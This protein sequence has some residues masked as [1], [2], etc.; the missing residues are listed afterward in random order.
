MPILRTLRHLALGLTLIAAAAAL[1]LFSDRERRSEAGPRKVVRVALVQHASTPALDEGV[2]GLIQGLAEQGFRDGEAITLSTYNAQGDLA[3]GNAIARQ[4]TTG[5]FDLVL[6]TSTPSM[7]AVANANRDGR[8][9]HVFT[10]VADPFGAGVG[11]DRDH[12][13]K[14]PPHMVG[15]GS[16]LPVADGF[17]L[18]KQALPSLSRVGVAWNPAE[19]NSEAFTLRAREACRQ[20]G[21][22]LLEA[23]VD[24]SAAV[25]EAVQSLVAR[26]AQALWVGGDNTMMS[27]IGSAIATA[28]TSRIPVFTI[29]PGAPDRGTLF[30]IGLDFHELGRIGGLLAG[31]VLR[32]EDPATIPIRDVQD[33]VP[34]RMVV[35]TVAL[36][37]LRDPWQIPDAAMA[38]ATVVVD[39]T[40]T[41]ERAARPG[42][43][44]RKWRVD[45]I[46]YN[47]VQDVE[48]AEEGVKAGFRESGLVE[49]RDYT[50]TVRNAQ[51]D[52]A[53]VSTLVDAALSERADMLVTFSTPTL[54]AA[55]QRARHVPI[56][57]TYVSSPHA[58]GAGR[59]DTDHL[60]N[61]TG[62]YMAPAYGDMIALIRRVMPSVKSLGTLFVPAEV[63]SV[64]NR[65]LLQ[66]ACRKAGLTLIDVPANTS[67]DVPDASLALAARRPDAICQIPGNLTA[68]AFPTVQQAASRARLPIFAFQTSQ[69]H[70]GAVVTVARDYADAGRQSA[71]L[72]V[73]VMRGERPADMPF[74]AVGKTRLVVNPSAARR[75]GITI[76]PDLVAKADEVVGPR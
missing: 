59:S 56:V 11:L 8:V 39:A 50:I 40:G 73:R 22:T 66:A 2:R 29:M 62:V 57:F 76:P 41:H 10:L 28:R 36:A 30:D 74:Q 15:H 42:A 1:L 19:S 65:D 7:Q 26:G 13:L 51:G 32:G 58:A 54:Q 44:A 64:F 52:M 25:T 5:E 48:E 18:A 16:F 47:Q 20:L 9:T 37:G 24:S 60:P 67:S 68:A 43:L 72:A 27:T 69:A 6:T 63:N 23:N 3:T 49:G 31:R 46:E 33:E 21:L 14:H 34:R 38:G 61:V 45:L 75:I 4:V 53:T 12:P 35:N 55:L 17:T 71:A 70:G